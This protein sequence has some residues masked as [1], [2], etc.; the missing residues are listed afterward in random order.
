MVMGVAVAAVHRPARVSPSVGTGR[1]DVSDSAVVM[2]GLAGG[3]LSISCQDGP[4]PL[5]N[6]AD[7]NLRR[8]IE[9]VWGQFGDDHERSGASL[10]PSGRKTRIH[11]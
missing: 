10:F 8:F 1:Q 6:G 9:G 3:V 2:V 7:R 4:V 11:A 5:I